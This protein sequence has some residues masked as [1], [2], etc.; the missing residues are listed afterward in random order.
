MTVRGSLEYSSYLSPAIVLKAVLSWKLRPA[1]AVLSSKLN[2]ERDLD[3]FTVFFCRSDAVFPTDIGPLLGGRIHDQ[4]DKEVH[5]ALDRV[6]N[7][8]GGTFAYFSFPH[9]IWYDQVIVDC[10]LL[11]AGN[12]CTTMYYPALLENI[13]NYLNIITLKNKLDYNYLIF[14]HWMCVVLWF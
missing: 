11:N 1:K 7:M 9:S 13:V 14:P 4:L 6:L 3:Y 2:T 12:S 10:K 8:A 5:P